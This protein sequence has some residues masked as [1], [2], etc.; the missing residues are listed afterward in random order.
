MDMPKIDPNRRAAIL[1]AAASNIE[2]FPATFDQ[3]VWCG[4]PCCM[5][6]HIVAQVVDGIRSDRPGFGSGLSTQERLRFFE[7][8]GGDPLGDLSE[9][10]HVSEA[11]RMIWGKDNR[12]PFATK[13]YWNRYKKP[14]P[15]VAAR[16]L[17]KRAHLIAR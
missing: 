10:M 9:E 12:D 6:G 17:R 15:A 1:L 3:G 4:T 7:A 14:G 8:L 11:A 13:P 5:A 16:A 2:A